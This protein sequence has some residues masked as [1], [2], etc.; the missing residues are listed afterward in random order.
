MSDTATATTTAAAP[1]ASQQTA[2]IKVSTAQ[3]PWRDTVL[4][5]DGQFLENWHSNVREDLRPYAQSTLSRYPNFNELIRSHH[6]LKTAVSK[7]VQPPGENAKPEEITAWR[8]LLGVPEKPEDYG[9]K[10]P[11]KLPDGVQWSDELAGGF[12]ALAH[13]HS[14]P[15]AAVQEISSWWAQQ[16]GAAA[17]RETEAFNGWVAAQ[18]TELESQWGAKYADNLV[19][20]Q[21]VAGLA[22]IDMADPDL[23]NNAKLI[24]SLH[25]VSKLISEDKLVAPDKT[26]QGLTA[27][28]QADDILHNAQNPWHEA[29][30]GKQGKARQEEASRLYLRLRAQASGINPADLAKQV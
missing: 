8:T 18:K 26:G 7:R 9:L 6:E 24:R 3:V 5:E 1:D 10:K 27:G 13:K 4:A 11:D 16:Q 19:A 22:G 23:G 2:T 29:Y 15:P 28:Q 20:A 17:G 12:A 30:M 25:E 14:L 21:R